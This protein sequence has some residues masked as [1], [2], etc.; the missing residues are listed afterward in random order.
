ML[1]LFPLL[2][3]TDWPVCGI[4]HVE[5]P[6]LKF[7]HSRWK[8]NFLCLCMFVC[9]NTVHMRCPGAAHKYH[10]TCSGKQMAADC[11]YQANR[12]IANLCKHRCGAVEETLTSPPGGVQRMQPDHCKLVQ[13]SCGA[14]EETFESPPGGAQCM[15]RLKRGFK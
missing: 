9:S 3:S 15:S 7:S 5:N 2:L 10:T 8:T 11:K 1:K 14:V 12:I 6:E 4:L 13:A